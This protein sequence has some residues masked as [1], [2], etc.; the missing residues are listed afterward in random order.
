VSPAPWRVPRRLGKRGPLVTGLGLGCAPIGN[1]FTSV[2]DSDAHA[3][4]DA[5]WAAGIRYFDTAPLYGHGLSERR[6]GE[7]LASRPRDGYVLSSKVGRL[8]R[9]PDGVQPPTIFAGVDDLV[10]QFDFSRDGVLR[11]IEESLARLGEDRL[12]VVLVHD[13]DDHEVE[14]ERHA[15][16]ALLELRDAGVVGAVG[17]GM[18][19]VAMLER[20][21][22]RVDLDCVLLA[23][24]YSLLDRSG[25]ERLLP[26]CA[27]RGVGV[28]LGGVFNSGVL[29]EPDVRPS[30]DYVPAPSGVVA[31]ARRLRQRCESS[32]VAL[33]AA[34]VQFAMRHPAVTLVLMGAR[35]ADEVTADVGYA[36]AEIDDALWAAL[37]AEG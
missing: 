26:G 11:S 19:Q 25:A 30:Y 34:A 37:E 16:P 27:E 13:P 23:G 28:V 4:V 14:A 33:P 32:G 31:R 9:P 10:P 3:T 18:N 21:V 36:A 5:A 7:A 1:L 6:L 8:L 2:S 35:S 12:D 15:F 24:R 17:C 20:F 29:V 22:E